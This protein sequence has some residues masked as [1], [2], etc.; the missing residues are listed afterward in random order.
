MLSPK[1]R[2]RKVLL[3]IFKRILPYGHTAIVLFGPARGQ[4]YIVSRTSGYQP[5]ICDRERFVF[6]NLAKLLKEDSIVY[7]IGANEGIISCFIALRSRRGKI[8]CFEPV[9]ANIKALRKNAALNDCGD[10][11]VLVPA[12]VS[13]KNGKARFFF[14]A[15]PTEGHLEE[16]NF[17]G[18]DSEYIEVET[19]TLDSFVFDS[20]NNAPHIIKID[21]EGAAG[22]VLEGARRLLGDVRPFLIIEMHNSDEVINAGRILSEA[23]YEGYTSESA[24]WDYWTFSRFLV[25]W[26]KE[27][28]SPDLHLTR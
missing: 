3:S 11:I 10:R 7:D 28:P 17:C 24:L 21:V 16:S 9:I 6:N 8:V 14:G 19:V 4:R 23:G 2:V 26:P 12:A 22:L 15:N 20:G 27:S 18:T 1:N 13:E 25:C 5:I